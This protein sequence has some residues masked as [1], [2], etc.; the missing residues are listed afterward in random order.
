MLKKTII[1]LD[2]I[3]IITIG[4]ASALFA[5]SYF[6][7]EEVSTES[8]IGGD[9]P[10]FVIM[11]ADKAKWGNFLFPLFLISRY[12]A[13]INVPSVVRGINWDKVFG[14]AI[15]GLMIGGI[16]GLFSCSRRKKEG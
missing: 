4:L 6:F 7:S 11:T 3:A 14:K 16:I 1:V 15:I 13:M 2:I 5:L 12:S 10:P 9:D 8:I